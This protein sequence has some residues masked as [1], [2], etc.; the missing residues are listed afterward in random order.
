[1]GFTHYAFILESVTAP[2]P[3]P[4]SAYHHDDSSRSPDLLG[5][6]SFASTQSKQAKVAAS[7]TSIHPHSPSLVSY[8][9]CILKDFRSFF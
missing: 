2:P 6:F 4:P 8:I 9:L 1:M 3:P 5:E 7:P